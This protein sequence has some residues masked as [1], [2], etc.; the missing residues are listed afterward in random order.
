MADPRGDP[1]FDQQRQ[2]VDSL[3]LDRAAQWGHVDGPLRSRSAA[4]RSQ[5]SPQ[6]QQPGQVP[7]I[8]Y[9]G[10]DPVPTRALQLRG[11]RHPAGDALPGQIR[12]NP[13]PRRAA[14]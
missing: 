2:Y 13:N 1:G 7:S 12:A 11:R 9:V 10:L 3:V 14:S 5:Q 4:P 6:V 8:P